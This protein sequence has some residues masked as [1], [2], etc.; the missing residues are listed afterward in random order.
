MPPPSA[1]CLTPPN[2]FICPLTAPHLKLLR[3]T[4]ETY[5]HVGLLVIITC[6]TLWLFCIFSFNFTQL[7]VRSC[8]QRLLYAYKPLFAIQCLLLTHSPPGRGVQSTMMGVAMS[9]QGNIS[10]TT[11]SNFSNFC[12]HYAVTQSSSGGVA[13]CYL[14]FRFCG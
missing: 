3:Y 6:V 9:V 12:T 11:G 14:Y 7:Y 2:I 4:I 8:G 10:G 1:N 13:I 5:A